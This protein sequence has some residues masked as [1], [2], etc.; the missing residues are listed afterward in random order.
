LCILSEL[1]LQGRT[2]GSVQ[3]CRFFC[4]FIHQDAGLADISA[5]PYF[6][7]AVMS[8]NSGFWPLMQR[9]GTAAGIR[10]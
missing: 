8:R 5:A 9:L 2:S 1:P 10:Q 3:A 7:T 4:G 6:L